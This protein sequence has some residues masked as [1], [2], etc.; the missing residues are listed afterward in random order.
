MHCCNVAGCWCLKHMIRYKRESSLKISTS[1][2]LRKHITIF[3]K[4]FLEDAHLF[5]TYFWKN[6][7]WSTTIVILPILESF[8]GNQ[9]LFQREEEPILVRRELEVTRDEKKR[10]FTSDQ[11]TGLAEFNFCNGYSQLSHNE[12]DLKKS[13]SDIYIQFGMRLLQSF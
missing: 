1:W 2:L 11:E 13:F 9:R 6:H 7:I 4:Y 12:K 8:G 5:S 10:P 3:S